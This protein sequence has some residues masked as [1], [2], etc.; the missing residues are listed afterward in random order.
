[1]FNE[2]L[3]KLNII[4]IPGIIFGNAGDGYFRASALGNK[5]QIEVANE[6]IRKYYEEKF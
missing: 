3:E 2:F 1:M 4:I 6:R 5:E